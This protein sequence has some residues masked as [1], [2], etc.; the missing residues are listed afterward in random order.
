MA[1]SPSALL[2]ILRMIRKVDVRGVLPA[3]HVPALVIQ[4]LDDL[5]TPACHGRYLADHLP[6]ARYFEQPGCH[7]PWLDD[8]ETM[9]A[10]IEDFVSGL[11]GQG[12]ELDRV[13][14]TIV[15][16]AG[17]L[18]AYEDTARRLIQANRGRLVTSADASVVATFD[19][20]ARA[21]RCATALR[22]AAGTSGVP[23]QVGVHTGEVDI[24]ADDIAGVSSQVTAR[25]AA[26]A[27]PGEILTSRIVKD[28]VLGSGIAFADRG[29]HKLTGSDD[30]WPVFAVTEP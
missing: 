27:Q 3:I 19:S 10:E 4:R 12:P 8:S 18:D 28:L 25:L 20:P 1:V 2:R 17:P 6:R 14:A 29:Q 9:L 15:C 23:V 22:D 16:T 24:G 5:I 11:A 13:L 26:V 7:L 30:D 21:I